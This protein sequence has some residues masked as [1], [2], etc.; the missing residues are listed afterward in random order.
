[1]SAS[2]SSRVDQIGDAA[3]SSTSARQ[4]TSASER[5]AVWT[6]VVVGGIASAYFFEL[7]HR[8]W[9][10]NDE[11]DFLAARTG[12]SLRELFR[13]HYEHWSTLPI[14]VYRLLWW[15]VGLRSYVPYEA[16]TVALHFL[17]AWLVR[18]VMRRAG[19][20]P[21][22][23]TVTATVLVLFGRG[24]LDIVW[25]FQITQVG[26]L[27]LGLAHLLLA[28]HDGPL[29]RRDRLGLVAGAAGLLCSGV[30]VTMVIVVGIAML[31]RRGWKIAA[32]H[33]VPL[34]LLY[35]IW[36][37]TMA[38]DT[39]TTTRVSWLGRAHF[40]V[41][42]MLNTLRGMGSSH[43]RQW[44]LLALLIIG[45]VIA[46]RGLS[47]RQW[48]ARAAAPVALLMG[49]GIFLAITSLGRAGQTGV[50]QRGRY[51]DLALAMT[52]PALG[53]AADAVIRLSRWFA[54]PV[55]ALLLIGVPG[56]VHAIET[57]I[58]ARQQASR[59]FRQTL[60]ALPRQP[61]SRGVPRGVQPVAGVTI[62][63]LLDGVESGRIPAPD[64]IS[65]VEAATDSLRLSLRKSMVEGNEAAPC[66]P[67]GS[68]IIVHLRRNDTLRIEGAMIR[69][70]PAT[71]PIEG[72]Y[73]A[74][75]RP[76]FVL[77]PVVPEVTFRVLPVPSRHEGRLCGSQR[78][79]RTRTK[80]PR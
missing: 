5:G 31:I 76:G 49:A 38:R 20:G 25:G 79:F 1:M 62:G 9:F 44:L 22:T 29:D 42:T 24:Y 57:A 6:F 12:G 2:T 4:P 46:W 69:V 27:T 36:W 73:P 43:H 45:L 21:W 16:L 3:V 63:W 33:T 47:W 15:T 40:V 11:W 56:N 32:V 48:S 23:A 60:L 41:V 7:G 74:T 55:F 30:A 8:L 67:V 35:L 52:L 13:P 51:L 50:T 66:R 68:R 64:P 72:T 53:V 37:S 14:L 80:T 75:V 77:S 17:A 19:V 78:L 28:G 71:G 34:G 18:C 39:Y 70:A 58:H 26:S 10:W 54:V 59:Q 61:L 65:R